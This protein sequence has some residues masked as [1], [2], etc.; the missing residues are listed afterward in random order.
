MTTPDPFAPGYR[1]TDGN[2]L[3]SRFANPQWSTTPSLTALAG[4]TVLTSPKIVET[5]T[6][7]TAASAPNAG[8]TIEQAL[9]GRILWIVNNSANT[10]V[11]FAEGGSTI[12]GIPGNI[13]IPL[14]AGSNIYIIA[15]DVNEWQSYLGFA[16]SFAIDLVNILTNITALRA[17]STAAASS[18]KIIALVYNNIAGD[19]GG[20]FYLD[21]SDNTTPDNGTTVIVD[22]VG[23]R[24]KRELVQA[25]YIAN[26]PAGNV[27]ATTVQAAINEIDTTLSSTITSN[28]ADRILYAGAT[29]G[30]NALT[31][32]ELS[33][34]SIRSSSE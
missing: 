10:V 32:G 8:V 16:A 19:G 11:V 24:W 34:V 30:P 13:G 33:R 26:T 22:T 15:T 14:T 23:N 7:I 27:A 9:P 3:N 1:L 2:D 20:L 4:G 21:A 12:D 29:T 18:P 31:P 17:W 25:V 28:V 5:V 6:Q